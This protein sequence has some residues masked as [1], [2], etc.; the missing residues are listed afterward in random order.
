[1]HSRKPQTNIQ[2]AISPS[3][4]KQVPLLTQANVALTRGQPITCIIIIIIIL[5]LLQRFG[6]T[7]SLKTQS[8]IEK[9]L[10]G[11]ATLLALV[12]MYLAHLQIRQKW[13]TGQS[14]V[15]VGYIVVI[16]DE[17]SGPGVSQQCFTVN[18]K[19]DMCDLFKILTQTI[20]SIYT[21]K[22]DN[23]HKRPVAN[24]GHLCF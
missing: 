3:P 14:N 5:L 16:K 1:M 22:P 8:F 19:T 23:R 2:N 6:S 12:E 4:S 21:R 18:P 20:D 10:A 11:S 7:A 24:P 9:T 15:K 17:S 13:V